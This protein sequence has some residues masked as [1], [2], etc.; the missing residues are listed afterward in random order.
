M[1]TVARGVCASTTVFMLSKMSTVVAAEEAQA[2]LH[3]AQEGAH[4][5]AEREFEVEVA[6]VAERH[7]EGA[8][9][10][11]AAGQR[12]AE[13]GPVHLH[14]GAGLEVEREEGLALAAAAAGAGAVAQDGDAAR[15]AERPQPLEHG[16][17]LISGV[18]SSNWRISAS[19]GARIDSRGPSPPDGF[20]NRVALSRPSR[21]R[22]VLRD[23]PRARAIAR[24]LCPSIR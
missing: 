24:A 18:S 7:D 11:R 4:R 22:T 3:A 19:Y 6:R 14:G 12:E 23:I 9:A 1:K 20:C 10:P 16:G 21:W 13:V 15:V 2:P 17:R 8:H 5:L